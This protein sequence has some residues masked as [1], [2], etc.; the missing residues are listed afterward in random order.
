[1]RTH[2]TEAHAEK[3]IDTRVMRATQ[4]DPRYLYAED[5]EAQAQA[6]QDITD[7]IMRD[8]DREYVV[9]DN[10]TYFGTDSDD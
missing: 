10:A 3:I 9:F 1:M 7:E 6:E 2:I 5:A 4:R 8:M